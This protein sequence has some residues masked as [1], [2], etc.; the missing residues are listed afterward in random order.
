MELAALASFALLVLGWIV[1]PDRPRPAV[2]ARTD[3]EPAEAQPLAA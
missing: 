1:A 2:V 3:I